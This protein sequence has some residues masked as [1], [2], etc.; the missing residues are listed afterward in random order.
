MLRR[1]S[2][3]RSKGA[4]G[5]GGAAED[6]VAAAAGGEMAA[7]V[8]ELAGDE[9]VVEGFLGEEGV[10]L[11]ELIPVAGGGEVDLEDAGVGGEREGAQA[12]V[13]RR[14]VALD[15]DGLLE[16]HAGVFDGGDEVEV[17]GEDGD[18]GE[19]DVETAFAGFDA[20]RGADELGGGLGGARERGERVGCGL[21]VEEIGAAGGLGGECGETGG[22]VEAA[23]VA[24]LAGDGGVGELVGGDE[25]H[26]VDGDAVAD[27]GVAPGEGEAVGAREPELAG[28]GELAGG[29]AAAERED[30]AGGFAGVVVGVEGGEDVAGGDTEAAGEGL[31]EGESLGGAEAVGA[32]LDGDPAGVFP[33]GNVIEAG[34]AVEG[35]AGESLAGGTTCLGRGAGGR[36]V[37]CGCGGGG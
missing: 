17:V 23:A 19:E 31:E 5:N 34:D 36:R 4:V 27:G 21:G 18:V 9:A 25:G 16:V 24:L 22:V 33:D 10:D 6:D 2:G 30:V 8:G 13:G 37:R 35:P 26:G 15:P 29:L 12:G 7:V 20:E 28:P 14:G 11:L 1:R 3:R 32:I